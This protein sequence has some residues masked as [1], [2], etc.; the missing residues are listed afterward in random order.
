[1]NIEITNIE[2]YAHC[3]TPVLFQENI[4]YRQQHYM[5]LSSNVYGKT[6]RI[7]LAPTN[8]FSSTRACSNKSGKV[9]VTRSLVPDGA[10]SAVLQTAMTHWLCSLS[11]PACNAHAPYYTVIFGLSGLT[12]FLHISEKARF[13]EGIKWVFWFCLQLLPET[14]HFAKNSAIHYHNCTHVFMWNVRYSSQILMKL[15]LSQHIFEKSANIKFHENLS[16]GSRVVQYRR[17]DMLKVTVTFRKFA[18]AIKDQWTGAV[19]ENKQRLFHCTALTEWF[20]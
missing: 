1:M 20:L 15:E 2:L 12:T 17:I 16:S 10:R 3:K 13:S 9:Q 6:R 11:Y 14:P 7:Y 19:K 18:I 5:A 4:Q 8:S